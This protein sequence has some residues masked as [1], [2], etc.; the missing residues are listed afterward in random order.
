MFGS[1]FTS[2]RSRAIE[3]LTN[4]EAAQ[5]IAQD[6]E[7]HQRDLLNAIDSG[8][9]PKWTAYI[10]VMTQEEADSFRWNP[11]DLTK[12]WPHGDFPLIE[13]GELGT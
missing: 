10:Q 3:H 1:S 6:R 9:F 13:V 11:F 7:S 8:N 4:D 12:V 5:V 2:R